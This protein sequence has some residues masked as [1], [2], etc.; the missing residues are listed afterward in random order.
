MNTRF[1]ALLSAFPLALLLAAPLATLAQTGGVRVG[2]PGPPDASAVLDLHPDAAVAPQGFLPPRLSQ[3]QRDAIQNPAVGLTVFNTNTAALNVWNGTKWVA[4]L[5]DSTPPDGTPLPVYLGYSGGVQTYTVPAGVTRLGVELAGGAGGPIYNSSTGQGLGGR[6]QAVLAVTPGQVLTVYVGG[7]G[8]TNTAGY[9]GGGA[10]TNGGGGGGGATDL[11]TGSALTNRVLVAGGGGGGDIAEGGNGGGLTGGGGSNNGTYTGGSGGTATAP[12]GGGAPNGQAGSGALGAP[13]SSASSAGGGGGGY[14][15]G[16][17]G[18][19]GA[20]G[21]G[22][23]SYAGAG[24]SDVV[25][26]QGVQAGNGYARFYPNAE[27]PAAPVLDGRNIVNLSGD[28]LGN[29]TATQALN[30]AGNPLLN[31]GRVGVGTPTPALSLDVVGNGAAVGLRN[32]AAWDHF[33]L[34]HDGTTAFFNA[35]GADN[36]LVLGVGAGASGSYTEQ[37]Y[38]EGLRLLPNGNVGVGTPTPGQK[39]EVAGQVKITGGAPGTGKVLTSDAAGVASWQV[40]A[41][42]GFYATSTQTVGTAALTLSP[43]TT[44]VVLS[45]NGSSAANGTITL[46]TGTNGQLLVLTNLDAQVVSVTCATGT[47]SLLGGNAAQFLYLGA[48][49]TGGWRRIN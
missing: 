22:G 20:G 38:T 8:D 14:F 10:A 35:G 40:P 9:N 2:T 15:G 29:H 28:N 11:R 21:G 46:G 36:G 4:Y 37:A 12:G 32:V 6:V 16:G 18:A 47:G 44:A 43:A 39:L 30:L 33:Y 24:T 17:S 23:S 5:A 48:G 41:T 13:A 45:D 49:G 25:H 19:S 34:T 26:A 27:F 31:T 42:G 7:A 1:R 3:A